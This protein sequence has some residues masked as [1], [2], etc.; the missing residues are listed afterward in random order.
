MGFLKKI[1]VLKQ[2]EEGFSLP[3]KNLSGLCR[4]EIENGVCDL[5]LTVINIIHKENI[6]Y[7]CL[8]VDGKKN[9]FFFDLGKRPS[10]KKFS[11]SLPPCIEKGF[12]FG[13]FAISDG[14]P[15]T[16]AFGVEDGFSFNLL[17]FKKMVADKCISER[18]VLSKQDEFL[19]NS[20]SS[21]SQTDID[22]TQTIDAYNDEAVATVN[23][24]DFDNQLKTKLDFIKEWN[25]ERIRTTDGETSLPSQEET[26]KKFL[27]DNFFENETDSLPSQEFSPKFPYYST[28]KQEL[29]AIFERFEEEKNLKKLFPLSKFSKINYAENKYYVVGLIK[30]NKKEKY[31]CYGV[32]AK[33]STTPPKELAGFCTF[34][35][36]SIFDLSGDG[37]WM[38]FQDAV[39]GNCIKPKA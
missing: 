18:K 13:I 2:T 25:N 4:L 29:D 17:E 36:L 39:F 37:Y 21:C 35:P 20:S 31:I 26:Q 1:L 22:N 34:I 23:Y 6:V 30:E 16:V 12:A 14:I 38:M 9:T 32:P 10:S 19:E 28:V 8:L 7:K 27:Q 24:Y 5:Y 3:N 33:Y 15:L 11:L